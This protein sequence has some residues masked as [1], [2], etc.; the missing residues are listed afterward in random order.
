MNKTILTIGF[1]PINNYPIFFNY[2]VSG[3]A[4]ELTGH[5]YKLHKEFGNLLI[6]DLLD[7]NI[8]LYK[9]LE[10]IKCFK[11]MSANLNELNQLTLL[12]VLKKEYPNLEFKLK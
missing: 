10:Y 4:D 8:N 11:I 12:N 7:E 6:V 1:K 9:H 2:E 5:D 3:N